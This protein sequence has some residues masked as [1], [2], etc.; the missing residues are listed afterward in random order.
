MSWGE[1]AKQSKAKQID[2]PKTKDYTACYLAKCF[3][4]LVG[5]YRRHEDSVDNLTK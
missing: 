5:E 1:Q 3:D 2:E 4:L